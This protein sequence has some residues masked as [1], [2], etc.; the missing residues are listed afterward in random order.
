MYDSLDSIRKLTI[1]T[2]HEMKKTIPVHGQH[3]VAE[4]PF[5]YDYTI[6]LLF[7]TCEHSL[8]HVQESK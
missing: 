3:A 2:T 8:R 6:V 1:L 4:G 7:Q 5:V